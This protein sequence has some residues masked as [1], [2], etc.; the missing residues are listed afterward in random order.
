MGSIRI[1]FGD[2]SQ[3]V[4]RLADWPLGSLRAEPSRQQA[5]WTKLAQSTHTHAA[6]WATGAAQE[7]QETVLSMWASMGRLDAMP[8]SRPLRS[9]ASRRPPGRILDVASAPR[10]RSAFAQCLGAVTSQAARAPFSR[11][12]PRYPPRPIRRWYGDWGSVSGATDLGIARI[13]GLRLLLL[14][15]APRTVL[16]EE[17]GVGQTLEAL[18]VDGDGLVPFLLVAEGLGPLV[19]GGRRVAGEEA[20][21]GQPL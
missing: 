13:G 18:L 8:D 1:R 3:L 9:R 12:H 14:L 20:V 10:F 6:D 15:L 2:C 21:L 16:L 19:P 5:G 11:G 7:L 4:Q 17:P